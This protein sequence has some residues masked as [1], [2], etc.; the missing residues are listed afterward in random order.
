MHWLTKSVAADEPLTRF[1]AKL[2]TSTFGSTAALVTATSEA[3]VKASVAR[4]TICERQRQ[5]VTPECPAV[6]MSPSLTW[7]TLL[8]AFDFMTPVKV[9]TSDCVWAL[10]S[11]IKNA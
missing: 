2:P 11:D 9:H 5:A 6:L 10:S 7:L 3:T 8:A 1:N 4:D